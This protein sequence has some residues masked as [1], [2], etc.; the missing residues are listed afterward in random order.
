M[1]DRAL[2]QGDGEPAVL[3]GYGPIPAPTARDLV[4]GLPETTPVWL[5]LL[6][7]HPSTGQLIAMTSKRRFFGG[8]LRRFT[9]YRDQYCRTPWC[10]APIRHVDHVEPVA[11]G[12]VTAASNSE[13]LCEACNQAKE[14]Y[15]WA[16]RTV[17]TPGT[18]FVELV[19]PTGHRYRSRAPDPPGSPPPSP[20]ESRFRRALDAVWA[21]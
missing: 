4:A 15:G 2:L 13:G 1:T 20:L 7:T 17:S 14:G 21:A 8:A 11:K 6:Y 19:T 5:R 3:E 9:R 16:A 18:H 12:G 10:G